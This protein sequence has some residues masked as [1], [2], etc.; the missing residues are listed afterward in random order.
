KQPPC[1]TSTSGRCAERKAQQMTNIKHATNAAAI[2]LLAERWP[3]CFAVYEQRRR[4]LKIGIDADIMAALERRL[5]HRPRRQPHR[6]DHRQR[7]GERQGEARGPR[8][9]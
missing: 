4:P 2:A 5:A 9:G 6:R 1:G 7:G 3:K 8:K